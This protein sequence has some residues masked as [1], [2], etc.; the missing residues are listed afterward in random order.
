[1]TNLRHLM[2]E[3]LIIREC[4][5]GNK[6]YYE[7]LYR[8]FYSY[9]MGISL[10]YGNNRED[11]LEILNDSF[12]K[13]FDKIGQYIPEQPFKAWLRRI[14]INTAI[15]HYRRNLKHMH[16]SDLDEA[17]GIPVA[18]GGIISQLTANDILELLEEIPQMHRMVF[19]LTEIEGF[20]HEEVA[21]MLNIPSSSSRVY[22]TRAKKALRS[23]IEKKFFNE[24]ERSIG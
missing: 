20:G 16:R 6:K 12:L 18:D 10:R 9:A 2:T 11:A 13:V 1:M 22:L 23:L 7:M 24:Y 15:D 8:H 17:E 14:I 19:N 21:G 5:S 3:E 4:R